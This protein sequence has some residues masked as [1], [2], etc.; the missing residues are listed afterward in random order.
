MRRLI[1]LL[2]AF[3]I[4]ATGAAC[5][6]TTDD[7]GEVGDEVELTLCEALDAANE[8][9]TK[10]EALDGIDN[11]QQL[12]EAGE[13]LQ[14]RWD[15]VVMTGGDLEDEGVSAVQ[16]AYTE[17]DLALEN[18]SSDATLDE[19]TAEIMPQLAAMRLAFDEYYSMQCPE[20]G[21]VQ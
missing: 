4:A 12:K 18:V 3:A 7:A 13:E 10:I 20:G 11:T 2:A 5:Q 9:L 15:Q 6:Q 14:L 8:Q 19:A 16:A 1:A 21:P 17:L